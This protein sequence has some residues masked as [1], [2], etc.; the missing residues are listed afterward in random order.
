MTWDRAQIIFF[1][2]P[3]IKHNRDWG[4]WCWTSSLKQFWITHSSPA[5]KMLKQGLQASVYPDLRAVKALQCPGLP[6]EDSSMSTHFSPLCF[7]YNHPSLFPPESPTWMFNYGSLRWPSGI[8][9][10][11]SILLQTAFEIISPNQLGCFGSGRV[12][13]EKQE[14]LR[15]LCCVI[16]PGFPGKIIPLL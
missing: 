12:R 3:L 10:S 11:I 4:L 16:L 9:Q 7:H 15:E 14:I 2:S 5:W 1:F 13:M 6:C 8:Q